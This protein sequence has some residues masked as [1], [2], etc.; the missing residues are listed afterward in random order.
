MFSAKGGFNYLE[1]SG[2]TDPYWSDVNVLLRTT[3]ISGVSAN[4]TSIDSGPN[5]FTMQYGTTNLLRFVKDAP[6]STVV[7]SMYNQSAVGAGIKFPTSTS[8]DFTG[9]FT[10]EC[11]A[12]V[13]TT[14]APTNFAGMFTSSLNFAMM[15]KNGSAAIPPKWA[16]QGYGTPTMAAITSALSSNTGV[17]THVALV[18]SGTSVGNIR[19]YVNGVLQGSSATAVTGTISYS[20]SNIMCGS[21]TTSPGAGDNQYLGAMSNLRYSNIARYTSD[22]T[23]PTSMLTSDANTVALINGECAAFLDYSSFQNNILQ[24]GSAGNASNSTVTKFT[25]LNSID[26]IGLSLN[27]LSLP[28]L[29]HTQAAGTSFTWEGWV[30]ITSNPTATCIIYNTTNLV[31]YSNQAAGA[32]KFVFKLGTTTLAT[33]ITSND[34]AWHHIAVVRVGATNTVTVYIDGISRLST[35]VASTMTMS[36]PTFLG[37]STASTSMVGY[38]SEIRIT[39][40]VARYTANFTPPTEPFPTS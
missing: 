20:A 4:K 9:D 24:T 2:N 17:W 32:N 22:Y 1:P 33:T 18:R 14:P 3:M 38:I 6:F 39:R 8:L 10:I 12:K 34:S 23:P 13:P 26:S 29:V 16:V 5:N 19:L 28:Q 27:Y 25:G 35:V 30:N 31:V 11:W 40:N 36:A 37:S 21:G 7:C 15:I